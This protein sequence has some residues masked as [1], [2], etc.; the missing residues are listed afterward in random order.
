[1]DRVE[2]RKTFRCGIHLG[3]TSKPRF[4]TCGNQCEIPTDCNGA[5]PE[6]LT[7]I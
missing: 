2:N 1:M 7:R 6:L 4:S 3:K 5:G